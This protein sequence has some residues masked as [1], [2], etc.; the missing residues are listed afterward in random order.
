MSGLQHATVRAPKNGFGAKPKSRVTLYDHSFIYWHLTRFGFRGG[1]VPSGP[2]SSS[3]P[4]AIS[5]NSGASGEGTCPSTISSK[6][7][8][9]ASGEPPTV[10]TRQPESE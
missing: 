1:L 9:K 4:L 5:T 7:F 2:I 8:G 10:I 6:S 3:L